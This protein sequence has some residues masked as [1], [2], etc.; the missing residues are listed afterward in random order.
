DRRI[1]RRQ[2]ARIL[3]GRDRLV[4][5]ADF[6]IGEAEVRQQNADVERLQRLAAILRHYRRQLVDDRLILPA[7]LERLRQ[8]VVAPGALGGLRDDLAGGRLRLLD[9]AE[10]PLR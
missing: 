6:L 8:R 2:F 9:I 1:T 5:L 10:P 7:R 4:V 3:E